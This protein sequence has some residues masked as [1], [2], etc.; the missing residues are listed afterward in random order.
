[1]LGVK[2]LTTIALTAS[3]T[4]LTAGTMLRIIPN[5]VQCH[6]ETLCDASVRAIQITDADGIL[7]LGSMHDIHTG[8]RGT[9]APRFYIM[10][11]S[12][13]AAQTT[14]RSVDFSHYQDHPDAIPKH[15]GNTPVFQ[16]ANPQLHLTALT[17]C[18]TDIQ[19]NY[20]N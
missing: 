6:L 10:Q 13:Q 1:M 16:E 12:P 17:V 18:E 2:T 4:M 8:A 14:L 15:L 20:N 9:I 3:K 19:R 5:A 7:V 11:T